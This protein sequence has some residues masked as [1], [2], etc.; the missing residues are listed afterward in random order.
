MSKPPILQY[1][2]DTD[3]I[4]IFISLPSGS[5]SE[6]TVDLSGELSAVIKNDCDDAGWFAGKHLP[7]VLASLEAFAKYVSAEKIE[8]S[9]SIP[10]PEME[11]LN[12]PDPGRDPQ[13]RKQQTALNPERKR[14]KASELKGE[15]LGKSIM[16][17]FLSQRIHRQ[18]FSQIWNPFP[19]W[20]VVVMMKTVLK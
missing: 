12:N 18:R 2:L 11:M 1:K 13:K 20:E 7:Q 10:S 16:K 9:R 4:H 14:R 15:I 3:R 5:S 6:T 17:Y 19:C 8:L